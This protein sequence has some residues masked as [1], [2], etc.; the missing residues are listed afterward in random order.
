MHSEPEFFVITPDP[1]P[2]EREVILKAF[3]ELW[4][5]E[6]KDKFSFRWRFCGRWW[7]DRSNPRSEHRNWR[8]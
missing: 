8:N 5:N 3:H 7:A 6:K 1:T 2:D 4:P